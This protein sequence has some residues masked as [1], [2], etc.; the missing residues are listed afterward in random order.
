M[1]ASKNVVSTPVCVAVGENGDS[2]WCTVVVVCAIVELREGSSI[3]RLIKV[4]IGKL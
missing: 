1:P 4:E 2:A 3:I